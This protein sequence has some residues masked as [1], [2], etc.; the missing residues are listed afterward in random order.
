MVK[1]ADDWST[2]TRIQNPVLM[3]DATVLM[4]LSAPHSLPTLISKQVWYPI[5]G[6]VTGLWLLSWDVVMIR[7]DA[8]MDVRGL[9]CVGMTAFAPSLPPSLLSI[10]LRFCRSV[11]SVSSEV[12]LCA[13][14][15]DKKARGI[16]T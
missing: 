3:T 6:T 4:F 10:H 12:L 11:S 7:G 1:S 2:H 9:M 15:Q 13:V 5:G 14:M 16:H 8:V